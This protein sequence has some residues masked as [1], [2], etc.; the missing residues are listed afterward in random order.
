VR[1]RKASAWRTATEK[2]ITVKAEDGQEVGVT[3]RRLSPDMFLGYAAGLLPVPELVKN[4]DNPQ[5]MADMFLKSPEALE[6]FMFFIAQ[7]GMVYPKLV[8]DS[9]VEFA[10]DEVA[11][12]H[13]GMA[14]FE[15]IKEITAFSGMSFDGD[16]A[17]FSQETT[18]SSGT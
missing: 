6:D 2:T 18:S 9:T 1:V 16:A 8:D 15:V 14:Y 10:E 11:P 12:R 5:G 3:I 17:P 4:K 7:K 13:L